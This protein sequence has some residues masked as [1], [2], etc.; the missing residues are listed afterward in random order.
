MD[1]NL[2]KKIATFVNGI[3]TYQP[4]NRAAAALATIKSRGCMTERMLSNRNC[5]VVDSAITEP[6]RCPAGELGRPPA[7]CR[8]CCSGGAAFGRHSRLISGFSALMLSAPA[9]TA[10]A[11]QRAPAV[12]IRAMA[13]HRTRLS[14]LR[15]YASAASCQSFSWPIFASASLRVQLSSL[16][17]I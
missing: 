17:G 7:G 12:P 3:R 9:V 16:T 6:V 1:S 13:K 11:N 8:R 14:L 15:Q 4:L 2:A 10:A 5:H